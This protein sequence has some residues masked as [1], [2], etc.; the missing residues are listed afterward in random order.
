MCVCTSYGFFPNVWHGTC[1]SATQ[2][3]HTHSL[4]SKSPFPLPPSQMSTVYMEAA[5]FWL[6][7]LPAPP[8]PLLWEPSVWHPVFTCCVVSTWWELSA[9]APRA[10]LGANSR[11]PVHFVPVA[12]YPPHQLLIRL[13]C[14]SFE[15]AAERSLFGFVL[16]SSLSFL[17]LHHSFFLSPT[18]PLIWGLLNCVDTLEMRTFLI[19]LE[20]R[21]STPA[22]SV[23]VFFSLTIDW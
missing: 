20:P 9:G 10:S 7:L 15:S 22:P 14:I 11:V 18:Y 17:S 13:S 12:N 4:I 23:I 2:H 16:S 1:L 8:H 6:H 3:I 5:M 21:A 19:Q